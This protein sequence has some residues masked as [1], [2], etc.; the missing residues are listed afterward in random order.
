MRP[1]SLLLLASLC[2]PLIAGQAIETAAQAQTTAALPECPE[3][4]R[5]LSVL[6]IPDSEGA[7][8]EINGAN[9]RASS[10]H[11]A[12]EGK[13]INDAVPNRLPK[14]P[15]NSGYG[16]GR[17]IVRDLPAGKNL[18][19]GYLIELAD[20]ALCSERSGLSLTDKKRDESKLEKCEHSKSA[21]NTRPYFQSGCLVI[22][23]GC[24]EVVSSDCLPG[25]GY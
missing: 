21:H 17:E 16:D 10:A 24:G 8:V 25:P 4:Y 14:C 6:I 13:Y 9:C 22:V 1:I 20:G 18:P 19:P 5:G 23:D 7:V 2:G 15:P 12:R 11:V 3:H